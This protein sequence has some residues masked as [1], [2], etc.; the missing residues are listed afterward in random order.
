VL[1]LQHFEG[2]QQQ[3]YDTNKYVNFFLGPLSFIRWWK[4][5]KMGKRKEQYFQ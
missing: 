3:C 5:K 2:L 1:L 4:G